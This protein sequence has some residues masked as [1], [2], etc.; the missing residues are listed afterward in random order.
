MP[1]L[2]SLIE[3]IPFNKQTEGNSKIYNNAFKDGYNAD[4]T[5]FLSAEKARKEYICKTATKSFLG[6]Y[7]NE[8]MFNETY[9]EQI[10]NDAGKRYK[11]W[12]IIT[13]TPDE[14]ADYFDKDNDPTD[15]AKP[16]QMTIP[17]NILQELQQKGFI[18]NSETQPL[19]W[20][21]SKALLAYFVEKICEKADNECISMYQNKYKN[22]PFRKGEKYVV[23]PFETLF[24][25]T[26][27]TVAKND[28]KRGNG[29]NTKS[30]DCKTLEKIIKSQKIIS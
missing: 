27:L 11:A 5:P 7:I 18:E 22:N 23:K 15:T 29:C 30:E 20:L 2:L 26:G 28:N 10:G 12:E 6:F 21:K 17:N 4:L 1:M 16:Q 9:F 8:T 24:N 3:R 19:K 25:V 14:F 13:Q